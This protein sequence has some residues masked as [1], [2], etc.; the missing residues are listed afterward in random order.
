ML[1]IVQPVVETDLQEKY[2]TGHSQFQMLN[3]LHIF[4]IIPHASMTTSWDVHCWIIFRR[5]LIALIQAVYLMRHFVLP[6]TINTSSTVSV[7]QSGRLEI[8]WLLRVYGLGR[9]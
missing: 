3:E 2:R 8:T 1:H 4:L 6:V 9:T 7:R 5:A